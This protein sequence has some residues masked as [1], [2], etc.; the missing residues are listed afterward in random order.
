MSNKFYDLLGLNKDDNPSDGQIKK[1]YKRKAL[2]WHPDRNIKNKEYA[3]KKFKEINQAY[4]IL[5]DPEKRNIYDTYGE[6]AAT[7]NNPHMKNPF[8]FS[9]AG[10]H[11]TFHFTTNMDGFDGL[12]GIHNMG[13]THDI[14]SSLFGNEQIFKNRSSRRR[15][16]KILRYPLYLSLEDIS[17]GI[18]KK[19]KT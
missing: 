15:R 16:P 4:E 6:Q 5:S 11:R 7:S 9:N 12:G 13:G 10:Q 2:K 17:R 3:E 19:M 14:L 1:A 8:T 18:T